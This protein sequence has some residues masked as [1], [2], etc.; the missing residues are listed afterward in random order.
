MAALE[1]ARHALREGNVLA[2]R[3]ALRAARLLAAS[4]EPPVVTAE[5]LE[6]TAVMIETLPAAAVQV[7]QH[8]QSSPFAALGLE[9]L[10]GARELRLSIFFAS[11]SC[12]SVL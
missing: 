6:A 4:T 9:R 11:S 7:L 10:A 8:A 12:A 1:A 2:A 3:S 5:D